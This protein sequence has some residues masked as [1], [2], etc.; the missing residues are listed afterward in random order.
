MAHNILPQHRPL[1]QLRTEAPR[2]RLHSDKYLSAYVSSDN[3]VDMSF[4]NPI[5]TES[6]DHFKVGVD[7]FSVNLQALSMLEFE[8]SGSNILFNFR[9]I[10]SNPAGAPLPPPLVD[11]CTF[12]ID[13][14]Y[15]S[16]SEIKVRIDQ[17]CRTL[18]IFI[19]TTGL[20]TD[21]QVTI[22][23]GTDRMLQN[24][25]RT[26][27]FISCELDCAGRLRF[28]GTRIFWSNFCIEI[29]QEKYQQL[30]FGDVPKLMRAVNA[31]TTG[32][33]IG[34]HP[35][36]GTMH[37]PYSLVGG[38][39]QMR[40]FDPALNGDNFDDWRS[41]AFTYGNF[42][43]FNGTIDAVR[44]LD[45][46]VGIE[47]GCSLPIKNSPM[48]DHGN[49]SPDFVLGRYNFTNTYEMV[50]HTQTDSCELRYLIGTKQLQSA[51]DNTCYHHLGPQQ[52]IQMLR[53]RLWARVRTYDVNTRKFG[54][55]T[56][57]MPTR[58]SD[59]WFIKLHF[60]HK[61]AKQY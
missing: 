4:R 53:L 48:Y 57:M 36:N 60:I 37:D 8:P 9:A 31:Q 20:D 6:A 55:Q 12:R 52:K 3:H 34:I 39:L 40:D 45:R 43:S 21:F 30:L 18:N 38:V 17:M 7:E 44:S 28:I 24:G 46:R 33:Y 11:A 41:D 5:L 2:Q 26:T 32:K 49:E 35:L 51:R 23:P 56:I 61:D 14:A 59:F 58:P 29:P 15:T 19:D 22:P 16:F 13:K 54:M 42:L 27:P 47:I 10:G 25:N 1:E 50:P